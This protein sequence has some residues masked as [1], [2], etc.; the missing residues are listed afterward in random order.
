M[1]SVGLLALLPA[2]AQA[3]A[4]GPYDGWQDDWMTSSSQTVAAP[5]AAQVIGSPTSI[6]V[7]QNSFSPE[8]SAVTI[9]YVAQVGHRTDVD[10]YRHGR[11]VRH[12]LTLNETDETNVAGT[13]T[14]DGVRDN[15]RY[16]D[17]GT[18]TIVVTSRGSTWNSHSSAQVDVSIDTR[19]PHLW[20]P[21]NLKTHSGERFLT[22][23]LYASESSDVMAIV[24]KG[25]NVWREHISQ[26][27]GRS[28]IT[29]PVPAPWATGAGLECALDYRYDYAGAYH[30]RERQDGYHRGRQFRAVQALK[31]AG[32]FK[33][34][35]AWSVRLIAV[36]IAGN[37]SDRTLEVTVRPNKAKAK[38]AI[39]AWMRGKRK[40][41]KKSESV[42][43]QNTPAG[44]RVLPAWLH[45]I[46]IRATE[47]AG[48]PQSWAT[49][50]T[51]Y[52]I[53]QHESG[54]NPRAQN[55]TST[56]YGMFQFLNQTWATVNCVKTSDAYQQSV[57]GL[58]YIERRYHTPNAAWK[59]WT[60]HHWY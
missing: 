58:R 5:I 57:C 36:D 18:F 45:P 39:K 44:P 4:G 12:L 42:P 41:P 43:L 7:S 31:K 32:L 11:L 2:M 28:D 23:P 34:N 35:C 51:L 6:T 9:A 55:P 40:K 16:M 15:G 27:E 10:V 50:Q 13:T 26:P 22:I 1:V 53:I 8:R 37:V 19:S 24:T 20:G 56:A 14:W 60:E 59:F 17:H 38:A 52:K 3:S 54:F 49:S 46:M 30:Y 25:A 21:D 33:K 29:V 48:V 47:G